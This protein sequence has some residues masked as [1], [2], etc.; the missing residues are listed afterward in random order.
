MYITVTFQMFC[1]SFT[2]SY[3]NSFSYEGKRALYDYL[4]ELE[5]STGEDIELDTVA[6]CCEYMEYEDLG[7]L[8]SDYNGEWTLEQLKE[9]TQVI[10]LPN[11]GFILSQN[12]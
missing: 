9:Q 5:E 10:E 11:G 4:T 2:G 8:L 1:D 7:E 6:L 12:F 3:K